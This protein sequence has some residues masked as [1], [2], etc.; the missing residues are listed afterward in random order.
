MNE[1]NETYGLGRPCDDG[2]AS[3]V[4]LPLAIAAPK[5]GF[6]DSRVL[7]IGEQDRQ[8]G[9]AKSAHCQVGCLCSAARKDH[10]LGC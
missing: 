2:G 7:N 9:V 6:A 4:D 8:V 10:I 1:T 5:R 3:A